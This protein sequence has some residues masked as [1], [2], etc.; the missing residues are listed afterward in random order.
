MVGGKG[1]FSSCRYGGDGDDGDGS[2]GMLDEDG[3]NK[4]TMHDSEGDFS[5]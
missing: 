5:C 2:I 3:G 1:V 4:A